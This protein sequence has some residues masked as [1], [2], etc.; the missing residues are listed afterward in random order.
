MK[1]LMDQY[2]TD[3]EKDYYIELSLGYREYKCSEEISITEILAEAD[4]ILYQ[5]KRKRRESVKKQ[6]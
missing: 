2:N 5:E 4:K 1:L 6:V 3:S